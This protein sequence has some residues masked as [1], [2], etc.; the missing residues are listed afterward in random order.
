[1]KTKAPKVIDQTAIYR[2]YR[3]KWVVLDQSRERV[4][5]SGKTLR[6]A[7]ERYRKTDHVEPPSVF[8]VPSEVAIFVGSAL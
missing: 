4:L 6:T 1:M 7:L 5:A 2:Q 8:K 3:G